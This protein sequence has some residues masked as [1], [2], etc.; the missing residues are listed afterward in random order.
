[1]GHST[2]HGAWDRAIQASALLGARPGPGPNGPDKGSMSYG[3]VLCPMA[4]SYVLRPYP[5]SPGHVLR[6]KPK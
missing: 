5:M 1:M 4:L 2:G 6:P 3:C